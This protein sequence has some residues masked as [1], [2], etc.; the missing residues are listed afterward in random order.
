[1]AGDHNALAYGVDLGGTDCKVGIV[2]GAG[3]VRVECEFPTPPDPG[4]AAAAVAR[5]CRDLAGAVDVAVDRL[6]VG[7][8]GPLRLDEGVIV[9]APNLR[10]R[11][12]PLRD[13]VA[14]AV[15]C[16]VVL[17]NDANAAAYGE[18]WV[19]AGR[20]ARVLLLVTLGTGVGGGLVA[21]GRVYHGAHGLAAEIGH[22]VVMPGGRPCSC[23]KDGCVEAYF[24]GHALTEQAG[25]ATDHRAIF[26]RYAAGDPAI[27]LWMDVAL[28]ALARGVGHAAVLFDPDHIVFTGGL[29]RS[30][31]IY[32]E[33]LLTGIRAGLWQAGP[34][35][36]AF[37]LSTLGG[38]AGVI[39]AA[40]LAL[41]GA[42]GLAGAPGGPAG[43]AG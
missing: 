21:H 9:H 28:D 1:M 18:F 20:E 12:V 41:H 29:T 40:G 27:V 39:G 42:G 6:G 25:G 33:R 7:A 4:D 31:A 30:W 15:G 43:A 16:P 5:A 32:G 38:R 35:P 23:G 26:A 37:G 14:R 19:G 34:A 11:E 3:R 17:D 10:W 22:Q 24:S 13:L 36:D 2:D 8:P